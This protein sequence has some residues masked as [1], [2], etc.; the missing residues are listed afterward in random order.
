MTSS[1]EDSCWNLNRDR[2]DTAGDPVD[3]RWRGVYS[4]YRPPPVNFD[5]AAYIQGVELQKF[6]GNIAAPVSFS[7]LR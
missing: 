5:M 2:R 1:Q 6:I 3:A 4:H 7:R